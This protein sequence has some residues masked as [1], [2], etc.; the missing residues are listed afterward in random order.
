V[1][2]LVAIFYCFSL[3]FCALPFHGSWFNYLTYIFLC[4]APLSYGWGPHSKSRWYD[5]Y[6]MIWWW[7][8]F[9]IT[10]QQWYVTLT[11]NTVSESLRFSCFSLK[12]TLEVTVS[13]IERHLQHFYSFFFSLD[14]WTNCCTFSVRYVC[15][16]ARGVFKFYIIYRQPWR[17]KRDGGYFCCQGQ[18]SL[19]NYRRSSRL[20]DPQMMICPHH[21][22]G[23]R[24]RRTG[25]HAV[26]RA[27]WSVDSSWTRADAVHC[28][29]AAACRRWV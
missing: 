13:D 7:I 3:Y 17:L 23:L 25:R 21:Q 1:L 18:K 27:V 24:V 8:K 6:D 26:W 29:R 5:I 10:I 16:S 11:G 4:T 22:G 20:E 28:F 12:L 2:L 9:F 19:Y 14:N 15:R